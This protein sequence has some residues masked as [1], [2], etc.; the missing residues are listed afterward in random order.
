LETAVNPF[1]A[2]LG[3]GVGAAVG[4]ALID[5]F[6]GGQAA[7]VGQPVWAEEINGTAL[8]VTQGIGWTKLYA[9]T[10]AS[11]RVFLGKAGGAPQIMPLVRH[12]QHYLTEGGTVGAWQAVTNWQRYLAESGRQ[13]IT[14]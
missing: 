1:T 3:A 13:A 14:Q 5:A 6:M 9:I 2:G 11:V 7:Q 4:V 8:V 12:W 10:P